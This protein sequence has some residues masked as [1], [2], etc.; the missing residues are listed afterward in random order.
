LKVTFYMINIKSKGILPSVEF[1]I[2]AEYKRFNF[3]K[4]YTRGQYRNLFY[5]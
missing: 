4:F 5:Y 3:I 1:K 2:T